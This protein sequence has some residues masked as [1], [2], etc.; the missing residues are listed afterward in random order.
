MLHAVGKWF[1]ETVASCVLWVAGVKCILSRVGVKAL[2]ATPGA[3]LAIPELSGRSW[4]IPGKRRIC[5]ERAP[6]THCAHEARPARPVL[7]PGLQ[8]RGQGQAHGRLHSPPLEIGCG[9][10]GLG[11]SPSPRLAFLAP[12]ALLSSPVPLP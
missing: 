7:R 5:Q 1:Q 2:R 11:P 9:E 8:A 4:R 3:Y 10:Y 12:W 6:R